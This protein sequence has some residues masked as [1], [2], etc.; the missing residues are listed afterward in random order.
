MPRPSPGW[1]M[2]ALDSNASVVIHL[3]VGS[4]THLPSV[5][6]AHHMMGLMIVSIRRVVAQWNP[7]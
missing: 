2:V 3:L 5:M 4:G 1:Q 6:F 7:G